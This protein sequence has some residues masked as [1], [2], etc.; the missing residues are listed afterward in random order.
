MLESM[1]LNST[2]HCKREGA[3]SG[4]KYVCACRVC[5]LAKEQHV[6]KSDFISLSHLAYYILSLNYKKIQFFKCLCILYNISF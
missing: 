3:E 2:V 4:G 1:N 6:Y 5:N